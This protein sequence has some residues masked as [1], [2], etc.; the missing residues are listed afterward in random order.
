MAGAL[1]GD[2]PR[3]SEE[4]VDGGTQVSHLGGIQRPVIEFGLPHALLKTLKRG[5]VHVSPIVARSNAAALFQ[6]VQVGVPV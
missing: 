5:E 3:G 1:R 6:P 4:L 2:D